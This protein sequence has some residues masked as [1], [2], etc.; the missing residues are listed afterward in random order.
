[1]L[2]PRKLMPFS[3]EYC[4][5][6]IAVITEITEKTPMVMPSI[7]STERSLFAPS[8]AQAIFMIS[9]NSIST[10]NDESRM[11]QAP[12]ATA[13]SSFEHSCFLRH[14]SLWFRHFSHSYLSAATGSRRDAVHAGANPENKPVIIETIMLRKTRPSEKWI[15]KDGKALPIPK[16]IR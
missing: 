10:K 16:H 5:A 9:P 1:M 8:D 15:G 2:E 7:V 14:S 6:P 13:A 12:A 3:I 11:S 4:K